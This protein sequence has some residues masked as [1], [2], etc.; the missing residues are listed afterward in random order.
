[1]KIS[2]FAIFLALLISICNTQMC[3]EQSNN[4]YSS[5]QLIFDYN[6]STPQ[7]IRI[8]LNHFN[9]KDEKTAF[10]YIKNYESNGYIL[11]TQNQFNVALKKYNYLKNETSVSKRAQLKSYQSEIEKRYFI[12]ENIIKDLSKK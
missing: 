10:D 1:M 11:V 8:V 3:I 6:R 9:K 4:H 7:A 5:D 12:A 2:S